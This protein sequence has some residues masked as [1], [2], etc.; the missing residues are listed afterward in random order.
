MARNQ[1]RHIDSGS[2]N[3]SQL[4]QMIIRKEPLLSL[5]GLRLLLPFTCRAGNVEFG[6]L[7]VH[8]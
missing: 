4:Q 5:N 8:L 2:S 1:E 3:L 6:R 7:I